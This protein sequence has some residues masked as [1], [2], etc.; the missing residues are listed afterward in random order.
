[1]SCKTLCCFCR[2]QGLRGL[3]MF[4][5]CVCVCVRVC[6]CVCMCVCVCVCACMCV[7]LCM[8]VCVNVCVYVCVRVC[9]CAASMPN[10][11]VQG[12]P[13][14]YMYTVYVGL[15]RTVHMHRVWPYIWWFP[16]HNYR[17]YTVYIYGTGIPY[18]YDRVFFCPKYI[19][20]YTPYVYGT[21]QPYLCS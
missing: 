4:F 1:M 10:T 17:T 2:H 3:C 18:M 5:V 19:Y 6:M 13:E 16:C 8:C 21:G 14:P 9:V 20:I 11:Y 7:F 15:A 12:W